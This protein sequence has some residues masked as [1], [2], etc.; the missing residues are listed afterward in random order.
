[1]LLVTPNQRCFEET[2]VVALAADQSITGLLECIV[3]LQP[4]SS[5]DLLQR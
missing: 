2:A 5:A 1:M 4:G 3:S